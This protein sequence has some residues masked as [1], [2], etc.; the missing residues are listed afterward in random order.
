MT[1]PGGY[2]VSGTATASTVKIAM[3]GH[4]SRSCKA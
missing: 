3:P 4:G 1:A 2:E